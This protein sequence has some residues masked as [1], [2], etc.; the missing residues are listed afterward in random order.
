MGNPELSA[1]LEK[2]TP[3]GREGNV[4]ELIVAAVFLSGDFRQIADS[5]DESEVDFRS[6]ARK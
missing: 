4:D 1:W 2:R 5:L 3:V 6:A